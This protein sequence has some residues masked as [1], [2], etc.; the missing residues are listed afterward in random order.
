[1]VLNVV[2]NAENEQDIVWIN[3]HVL[4]AS[5]TAALKDLKERH[6][7]IMAQTN[8]NSSS[9]LFIISIYPPSLVVLD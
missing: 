2:A 5:A 6:A 9:L 7:C 8:V 4:T 1:M 3:P